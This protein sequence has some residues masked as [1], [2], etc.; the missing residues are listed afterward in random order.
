M[1][2]DIHLYWTN[3]LQ[4][5]FAGSDF[6]P[7]PL[8]K[9]IYNILGHD[10]RGSVGRGS[11]LGY[12][13]KGRL[14]LGEGSFSNAKCFFDL[15]EDIIIGDNCAIGMSV[16]FITSSHEIG[17]KDK[18]GG[19]GKSRKIVIGN[20]C[21][22]GAN[23]SILPGVTIGE[24]VVIGTGAVVIKDCEPNCVYAGVPAKIVRRLD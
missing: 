8:R 12:S 3:I 13:P 6:C 22:I 14:T 4:N 23:V 16:T 24:G 20:G 15:S 19:M 1:N 11:F 7:R 18:R 2:V 10:I 9:K 5:T 17:N 21:W